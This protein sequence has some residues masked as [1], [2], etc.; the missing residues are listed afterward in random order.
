MANDTVLS[1]NTPPRAG[2]VLL[3][4][5]ASLVAAIG[6]FCPGAFGTH[7]EHTFQLAALPATVFTVLC[8]RLY[9]INFRTSQMNRWKVLSVLTCPLFWY[10]GYSAVCGQK[11]WRGFSL[12][13]YLFFYIN[14]VFTNALLVLWKQ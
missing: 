7:W 14:G 8:V 10:V 3:T 13:D 5:V 6:W 4:G 11:A 1:P 2:V 12:Q 9:A